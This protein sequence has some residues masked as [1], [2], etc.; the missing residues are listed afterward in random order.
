MLSRFASAGTTAQVNADVAA[1]RAALPHGALLGAQSWLTVTLPATDAIAPW[2]WWQQA[3]FDSCTLI[4]LG[5]LTLVMIKDLLPC[6][7]RRGPGA[8]GTLEALCDRNL[9]RHRPEPVTTRACRPA[10]NSGA[11][12]APAAAPGGPRRNGG[13]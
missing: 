3:M 10:P 13:P 2:S 8:A 1:L 5:V 4:A 12:P 6:P 11:P 9:G 7:K